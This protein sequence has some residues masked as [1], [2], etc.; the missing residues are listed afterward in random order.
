M[1]LKSKSFA[2]FEALLSLLFAV[3]A[4]SLIL[5]SFSSRPSYSHLNAFQL[6]QDFAEASLASPRLRGEIIS[7]KNG[8]AGAEE[9][10]AGEYAGVLEKLG[11]YCLEMRVEGKRLE[12]NCVLAHSQRVS[13]RRMAFDGEDF[14]E[15]EFSLYFS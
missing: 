8:V 3:A 2:S 6:A 7:F 9:S 13:A 12:A 5:P 15:I 10:L 1:R 11:D 4:F 14:F